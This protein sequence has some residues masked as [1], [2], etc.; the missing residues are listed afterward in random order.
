MTK[1]IQSSGVNQSMNLNFNNKRV[2]TS[3]SGYLLNDN[4]NSDKQ[5]QKMLY[6]TLNDD[7]AYGEELRFEIDKNKQSQ[8]TSLMNST[9]TENG[10]SFLNAF[11]NSISKNRSSLSKMLGVKDMISKIDNKIFKF[12]NELWS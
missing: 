8:N 10:N 7:E 4:S 3:N 1:I 6:N 5:L 11:R 12:K 9:G 2:T